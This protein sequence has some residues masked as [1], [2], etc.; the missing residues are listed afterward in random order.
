MDVF[1]GAHLEGW[2]P[3][4]HQKIMAVCVLWEEMEMI[5]CVRGGDDMPVVSDEI[6][7]M[8]ERPYRGH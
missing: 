2:I 7:S 5:P 6:I 8:I 4:R 3:E 1:P